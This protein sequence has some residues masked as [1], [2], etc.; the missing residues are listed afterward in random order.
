VQVIDSLRGIAF[1]LAIM[2]LLSLVELIIPLHARNDASRRHLMPNLVLTLVSFA[3]GLALNALLLIGL[4][5]FEA[6]GWGLF[7]AWTTP[8]LGLAGGV[9]VL[10][11]AWYVTHVALHKS[12]TLWRFHSVHHSDAM[13]DVTTT[14][15]QHPGEGL[16]RYAFL[17]AFGL[18]FGVSPGAFAVYRVWSVMNGC[19]EH[20][21]IRLPQWLDT[22]ISSIFT[23]PN[24][25]KVHHS[26]DVRFADCNFG[27]IFSIW[28]RIGRTFVPARH[29]I[30]IV[31]GLDG[32]DRDDQQTIAA[33]LWAPFRRDWRHHAAARQ[34]LLY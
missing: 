14:V 18:A 23:S 31:Y 11:L 26:R 25:H 5:W 34:D 2:A 22:A 17:A 32:E 8:L 29:G 15:R 27:N 7:N 4:L 30:A 1:L 19:A 10:D 13:V 3:I 28:D 16:V 24:L 6:R 9:L 12:A 33:L 21:N 20:A